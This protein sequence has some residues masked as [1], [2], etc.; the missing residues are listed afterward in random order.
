LKLSLYLPVTVSARCRRPDDDSGEER[1]TIDKIEGLCDVPMLEKAK[2]QIEHDY[3]WQRDTESVETLQARSPG[4]AVASA[5]RDRS[6]LR[7]R[8]YSRPRSHT[9]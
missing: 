5:S 2:A 3:H 8:N 9:W 6:V 4:D 1:V 7:S